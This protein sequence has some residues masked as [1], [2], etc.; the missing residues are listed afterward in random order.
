MCITA[1]IKVEAAVFIW[2]YLKGFLYLFGFGVKNHAGVVFVSD[3][4]FCEHAEGFVVAIE[5]DPAVFS[6][7]ANAVWH[8]N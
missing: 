6:K 1:M 4:S 8:V 3:E 5:N 2:L 7:T